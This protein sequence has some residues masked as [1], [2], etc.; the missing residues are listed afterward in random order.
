M[1][2]SIYVVDDQAPVLETTVL[3]LRSLGREWE[4]TGFTEPSAALEAVRAK[5]PDVVLSDE[6]MPG[7]QG[8][9][10]LEHVRA[11]SPNTIRLIMSGCVALDKLTLITSAHQYIA[12][13]FDA[14]KLK[15]LIQRSFVAQERI[16]NQGLQ[17]LVTSIRSIPSLPQAH[18]SLL[19]ELED[20]DT[21]NGTIARL[22]GDDPGLSIKVLQLA[23]SSLFG[24]GYVVTSPIDAVSCLGTEMISAIVLSQSVF[25]HYESL[26][27]RDVDL[28][29]V[30]AH[31]WGT[32]CLAQFLCREKKLPHKTGE[33]AFL[34]GLLHE[35]GRFILVDN[36][37]D[38]FEIAC[39]ESR[40]SKTPLARTLQEVFQ[41]TPTQIAAYVLELWG[42]PAGVIDAISFLDNPEKDPVGQFSISSA[43]YIADRLASQTF[44]PDPFPIEEWKTKY[45]QSIDCLEDIPTWEEL[46]AHPE[47]VADR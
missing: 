27:H 7:M 12:K 37:P 21:P 40:H 39:Q 45:L 23:N 32:A 30:W 43:L 3:V 16:I 2:R 20:S 5:P 44:P 11:A 17:S 34:A 13:P 36:F 14:Y 29:R 22:I 46:S 31:C 42:L 38:K 19:K 15:E 24:R 18:Q 41:A 8:S 4:V 33:E 47:E 28:P 26:R 25:K 1:K 35:A 6:M 10:L 9:M